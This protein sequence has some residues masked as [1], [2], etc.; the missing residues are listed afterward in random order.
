MTE[1]CAHGTLTRP[2]DIRPGTIGPAAPGGGGG[3]GV[4]GRGGQRLGHGHAV[5]LG[6][7]AVAEGDG[8]RGD[9]LV[10]RTIGA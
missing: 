6:A 2:Q 9:V 4:G 5:L 8:A 10:A 1:T 3:V 7:V